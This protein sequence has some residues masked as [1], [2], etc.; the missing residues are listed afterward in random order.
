MIYF[1]KHFAYKMHF[2]LEIEKIYRL[3]KYSFFWKIIINYKFIFNKE[4]I[5]IQNKK[6]FKFFFVL[7]L[8][9]WASGETFF[10]TPVELKIICYSF[11]LKNEWF[12]IQGL[13]NVKTDLYICSSI[14]PSDFQHKGF[15]GHKSFLP[16][17]RYLLLDVEFLF[18]HKSVI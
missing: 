1:V 8:G 5:F 3:L 6:I 7:Y 13:Q 17:V 16:D 9:H 4:Y 15:N 12:K 10:N 18:I 14:S 2:L 11:F